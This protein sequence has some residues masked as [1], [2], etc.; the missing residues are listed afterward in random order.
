MSAL[1]DVDRLVGAALRRA[2][3]SVIGNTLVVAVSGGPDSVALLR[4]LD[5]LS[6]PFELHL[7]VAHLDHDFRGEEAVEDARFVAALAGELGL[8]CTVEKQDPTEYQAGRK[9]TSFEQLA[10]E[11]RYS[12][13]ASTARRVGAALVALGH[14][15]DDQAETV[16]LHVLRGSGLHGLRGMSEVAPWPWPRDIR[17][18]KIFRPL[19][20]ATKAETAD[21]CHQL[22][23]AYRMDSGNL[24][25]RFTRNRVR[26]ELLP[27]LAAEYNP[28]IRESLLRLSRTAAV[29]TDFVET[30]LDRLW[31][32]LADEANGVVSL[33]LT[34]LEA[35]HPALRSAALRRA[36]S[37]IVGDTRRLRESH[38]KDMLGMIDGGATGATVQLPQGLALI[39][40]YA[41]LRVGRDYDS[42]CPLP[43]L[44][45]EHFLQLPSSPGEEKEYFIGGWTVRFRLEAST[46]GL[47]LRESDTG[48]V[49]GGHAP[50]AAAPR[51]VWKEKFSSVAIGTRLSVRTWRAGD[52]FQPLG[53]EGDKKLQDFYTDAKTPRVWRGRIPL[54]V[55]ERGIAWVVGYR[56][57]E[58]AKAPPKGDAGDVGE[59]IWVD[60]SSDP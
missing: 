19:L 24:L 10:R 29:E 47:P 11:M 22:G 39:R 18:V 6:S 7:H 12:F 49:P 4:S 37:V 17:D 41:Y 3:D 16:L 48:A 30:E 52:R 46:D 43:V 26:R 21:Y 25:P 40:D 36:Y 55:T 9:I 56:V 51:F 20:D 58:W 53:M 45:G 13:L 54:L 35:L 15:S 44:E 42:L 8:P 32:S 33:A 57:A 1:S 5:R 28:R 50:D 59:V 31:P 27:H 23:Q 60:I 14:T 38:V 2:G 34:G